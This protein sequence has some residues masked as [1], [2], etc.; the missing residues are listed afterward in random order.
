MLAFAR[1][2]LRSD[3]CLEIY[4]L[5]QKVDFREDKETWGGG[6]TNQN[7]NNKKQKSERY[8]IHIIKNGEIFFPFFV[9]MSVKNEIHH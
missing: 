7:N 6:G 2:F 3:L 9:E 4:Y 1:T 8:G 5:F